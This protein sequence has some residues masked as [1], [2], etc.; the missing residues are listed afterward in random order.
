MKKSIVMGS[1]LKYVQDEP[2]QEIAI[3]AMMGGVGT[4]YSVMMILKY[5]SDMGREY[6]TKAGRECADLKGASRN[7]CIV[8]FKMRALQKQIQALNQG[9]SKCAKTR[10]QNACQ[11]KINDKLSN[12][13]AKKNDLQNHYQ[14]FVKKEKEEQRSNQPGL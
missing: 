9:K 10:N 11:Q 8:S 12:L 3:S 14:M 1:Y 5:A 13:Q 2:L 4:I 7:V 6:L